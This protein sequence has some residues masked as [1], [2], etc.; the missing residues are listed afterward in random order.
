MR[1]RNIKP[2]FFK[3]EQLAGCDPLARI[4]FAGL[5][6]CS[7]REGRFE[8]RPKRLKVE[9]LP[10]DNCD[11]G[12][13]L[14]ELQQHNLVFAYSVNGNDYGCIPAFQKHQNPHPHEKKSIIPEPSTDVIKC[15]YITSKDEKCKNH[16]LIPDSLPLIPITS[17][18]EEEALLAVNEEIDKLAEQMKP[19]WRQVFAFTNTMRKQKKHPSAIFLALSQV[20]LHEP[21]EP[22]SYAKQVVEVE[23]GNFFEQDHTREAEKHKE[24]TCTTK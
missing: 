21:K 6:C 20:A 12:E 15:N 9:I 7:D 11:I 4:L 19:S 17:S 1:S 10:Y 3:S 14:L 18:N 5:W 2:G 13:L 8:W 22:W 24:D 16:L 23:S